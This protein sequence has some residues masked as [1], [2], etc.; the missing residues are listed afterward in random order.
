[1]GH[2]SANHIDRP[3]DRITLADAAKIDSHAFTVERDSTALRIKL[4]VMPARSSPSIREL[5]LIGNALGPFYK[6]PRL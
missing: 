3:V 4:D 1:M 6:A 5:S 2:Q